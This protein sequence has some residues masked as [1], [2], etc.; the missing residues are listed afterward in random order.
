MHIVQSRADSRT[1]LFI[2]YRIALP[3]G[4]LKT[5]KSSRFRMHCPTFFPKH[6]T[7]SFSSLLYR[8]AK[9]ACDSWQSVR[10][11]PSFCLSPYSGQSLEKRLYCKDFSQPVTQ[12][13]TAERCNLRGL[14]VFNLV[15]ITNG[16]KSAP[17]LPPGPCAHTPSGSANGR[18]ASPA[19]H[20]GSRSRL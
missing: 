12:K 6:P 17:D 3:L 4:S 1:L 2:F 20:P 5:I 19:A 15:P 7:A 10:G 16:N 13:K 18:P 14:S 9:S 8:Y 11:V